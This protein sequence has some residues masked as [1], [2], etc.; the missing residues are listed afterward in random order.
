MIKVVLNKNNFEAYYRLFKQFID[1]FDN[2][3]SFTYY[4][5]RG[6]SHLPAVAHTIIYLSNNKIIGYGHLDQEVNDLWLGIAVDTDARGVGL[7][8]KIMQDLIEKYQKD[9]SDTD[10]ILA[11]GISNSNALKLYKKFGFTVSSRTS[12]NFFMKY[13]KS[14]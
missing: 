14:S 8:A 3:E 2:D 6:V 1:Q 4:K 11:V 9:F 13:V 10:L 7:G 12:K 5:N